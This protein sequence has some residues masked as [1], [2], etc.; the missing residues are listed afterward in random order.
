MG[1]PAARFS[2]ALAIGPFGMM[3]GGLIGGVLGDRYGRR[4][5]LLGS[6]IAFAVLTLAIAFV[7]SMFML[8][9]AALPRWHRPWRRHAQRRNA[10]VRIR[11]A[12]SAAVRGDADDRLH[13]A[14]RLRCSATR[15]PSD[16]GLRLARAV[17]RLAA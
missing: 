17:H 10:R 7:D 13:S 1:L 16:P 9:A 2:N 11:A 8:G 3:I 6:V 5:A 14:R 4:T 15:R 12:S